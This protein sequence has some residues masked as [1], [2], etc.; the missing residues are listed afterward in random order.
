MPAQES[1]RPSREEAGALSANDVLVRL[2][3]LV[4]AK[5]TAGAHP[6]EWAVPAYFLGDMSALASVSLRSGK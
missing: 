6:L 5:P 2:Q 1:G 3:D 4:D